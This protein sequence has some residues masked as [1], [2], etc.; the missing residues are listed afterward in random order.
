M[1]L[2][3]PLRLE[4]SYTCRGH[5][6]ISLHS[7]SLF[8]Y[9]LV[10]RKWYSEHVPELAQQFAILKLKITLANHGGAGL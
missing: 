7:V 1:R 10:A 3:S 9:S 8:L 2:F 4:V 5:L 6:K